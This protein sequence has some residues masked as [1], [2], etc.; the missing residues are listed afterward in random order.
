MRCL[1]AAVLTSAIT[2]QESTP[3]PIH[4]ITISTRGIG[5]EW[6][7]AARMK[8]TMHR[9][10]A[11]GANWVALHPYA[12]IRADG[13]V[14]WRRY[15]RRRQQRMDTATEPPAH[16]YQPIRYAHDAGFKV[17]IKPHLAY[18]GSP[19]RWRGEITF[20]TE[21]AWQRFFRDYGA[22]VELLARSCSDADGLV[23]GTELDQTL[24]HEKRWRAIIARLRKAT[25]TPLTY[26][27]NWNL[28][29]Q[30]PF[31]D[32]LDVVGIQAYFPLCDDEDP[33]SQR[34][35]ACWAKR[36]KQLRGFADRQHKD[37]VFTELGYN[38]SFKA[39]R[40][41]WGYRSDGKAAEP[42]QLRCLQAA[43]DAIEAEPRVW[44]SFLWKWFPEPSA[45][46]RNF[47]LATPGV[48]SL[49]E[50]RWK[51]ASPAKRR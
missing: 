4:G 34:L 7:D 8:A 16:W 3:P 44:G 25:K 9:I 32:A 50:Q 1:A 29:E 41:P 39:A 18:W 12:R 24:V 27:A 36:M 2:A 35:A 47:P 38:T 28:Y 13:R 30:V 17:L 26:A 40:E 46:G 20:D 33:S 23:I 48:I 5:R 31:W 21:A 11:T 22:W 42:L 45:V 15:A 14:D 6:A 19:F 49:L 43:L 10:Q 37:I 51:P